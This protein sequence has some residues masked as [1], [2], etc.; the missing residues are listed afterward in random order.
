MFK[1]TISDFVDELN[2]NQIVFEK[3][4]WVCSD[5]NYQ[6]Y[7][8]LVIGD[9]TFKKMAVVHNT[10]TKLINLG[11]FLVNNENKILKRLWVINFKNIEEFKK[12]FFLIVKYL[13]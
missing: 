12:S 10:R 13:K 1:K 4:K 9:C 3:P 5:P 7:F 8:L 6:C 2:I 11:I